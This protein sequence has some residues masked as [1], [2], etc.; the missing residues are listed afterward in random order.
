VLILSN[1]YP[2]CDVSSHHPHPPSR[3]HSPINLPFFPTRQPS[4]RTSQQAQLTSIAATTAP[5]TIPAFYVNVT[6]A[7]D[8]V[9]PNTPPTF[10]NPVL[11]N[12]GKLSPAPAPFESATDSSSSLSTFPVA[13]P[14]P[15]TSASHRGATTDGD[16]AAGPSRWI[17][18]LI[19]PPR[20]HD[21]RRRRRY[22]DR[23][24]T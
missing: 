19:W 12:T 20:L 15:I 17:L 4:Y 24:R 22:G 14:Q 23:L 9:P 16:D 6:P 5:G 11:D 21:P 18:Q 1:S 13:F 7:P 2:T 3:A 8:L 10:P